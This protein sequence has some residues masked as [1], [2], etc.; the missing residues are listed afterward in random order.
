MRTAFFLILLTVAA[1]LTVAQTPPRPARPAPAPRRPPAAP[2]RPLLPALPDAPLMDQWDH[3][4]FELMAP[5]P[6][7]H[8]FDFPSLPELAPLAELPQ[9]PEPLLP[10]L[11]WEF[12]LPQA[13]LWPQLPLEPSA[14]LAPMEWPAWADE[15]AHGRLSGLR[16]EQGTPEDSLFR[17]A[18]QALNQGEYNRAATLFQSFEQKYPRSRVAPAAIYWRAFALYRSG[19]SD[20]LRTA[21]EALKARQER[22]PEAASDA[23]AATLRTRLYA[24][25]AARG[26]AQAT[27]ALR[28]ANASGTSCDREEMDVRAEALNALAQLDA[29]EARP[30]LKRVL[31]RRD[32]CSATLRRRAVYILGRSGTE[33]SAADLT[34]A[35]K[36]DPDPGVRSDAIMFIG[37]SPGASSVRVLEQLFNESSDERTR[38]AA[39]SALRSKGGPEAK[40]A[41]RAIIEKSDVPE[42]MRAE[43]IQQLARSSEKESEWVMVGGRRTPAPPTAAEEE[44]AAFL[45]GLYA[46]TESRGVKSA[47]ISAVARI[48]GTA[49]EQW[50]LEIAKNPNE[51]TA[52]R[53]EALSRI[54][55]SSLPISE[56]SKLFDAL[57]ERE[58]RYAVVNQLASRDDPAAVDKLIE[59]ARSGTDPQVRRQAIAALARKNDP[60][61][62]KLLLEL[63]EKP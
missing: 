42:R 7:F 56:L 51:E 61:T 40:R 32:E 44:D 2:S 54:K 36:N 55:T 47:I 13:P 50:L 41:L 27:A 10:H 60:R 5:I 16:P 59:I 34:E 12:Q 38:A 48:G 17:R 49:N 46:K 37:R 24:A 52:L 45:R 11:D 14:P 18:R 31:A 23:D 35:A 63:V 43:A 19:A 15:A 25:L 53:R 58:L 62:M 57:P 1:E 33:E 4:R 29:P 28:A 20:E 9:L 30:T 6:Q 39:L 3:L 8:E 26:D 21:L 22:Y